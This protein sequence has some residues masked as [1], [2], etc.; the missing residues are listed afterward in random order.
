MGYKAIFQILREL[1][2]FPLKSKLRINI[3]YYNALDFQNMYFD[4]VLEKYLLACLLRIVKAWSG[5][6]FI[7]NMMAIHYFNKKL[8]HREHKEKLNVSLVLSE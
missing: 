8:L 7:Y 6:L 3:K 1:Y 4:T 2:W 5:I